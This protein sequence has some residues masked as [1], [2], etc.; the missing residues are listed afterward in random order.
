MSDLWSHWDLETLHRCPGRDPDCCQACLAW[1][2]H[3]EADS[4]SLHKESHK[5]AGRNYWRW[6]RLCWHWSGPFLWCW[7]WCSPW[8]CRISAPWCPAPF[9]SPRVAGT[10][11][12][13]WFHPTETERPA[14]CWCRTH[15]HSSSKG[16]ERQKSEWCCVINVFLNYVYI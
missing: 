7:H 11:T 9:G 1:P 10:V 5:F 13:E 16:K 14:H 12:D 3:T 2:E 15:S 4:G 6:R 8:P